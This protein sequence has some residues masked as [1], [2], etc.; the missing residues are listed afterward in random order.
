MIVVMHTIALIELFGIWMLWGWPYV[1]RA[2]KVQ[3]RKSITVTGPSRTGLLLQALG[4]FA[5]WWFRAEG[6]LRVSV[7][8]IAGSLI[9]GVIANVLMWKAIP[10]LGRQFR[11]QAGLY[12]DHELVR[13]GPYAVVR[14]PIYASVIA[15]ALATGI[16]LSPW[17]WVAMGTALCV[18]GSEI[19]IHA[20]DRL[21]EARFGDAF[22]Q[23]QK[24]VPAYLPLVR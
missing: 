9:F 12:E 15:L 24:K 1:F 13:T 22:R 10:N 6:G 3:K 7:P 18:A 8:A 11:V 5:I 4:F 20:E 2:P 17:Q 16:L 23:Y 19:R 21:L 14:H